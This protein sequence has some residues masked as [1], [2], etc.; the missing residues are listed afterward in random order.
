MQVSLRVWYDMSSP[1]DTP[2]HDATCGSQR[3]LDSLSSSLLPAPMGKE[4]VGG[5]PCSPT[6]KRPRTL[7]RVHG[8]GPAFQ[9]R[10]WLAFPTAAIPSSGYHAPPE[11]AGC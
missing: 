5:T 3:L 10:A 11:R 9:I 6:G 4:A 8:H 7:I 1:T 2:V